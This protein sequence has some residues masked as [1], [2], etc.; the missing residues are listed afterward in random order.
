M[1]ASGVQTAFMAVAFLTVAVVLCSCEQNRPPV[2]PDQQFEVYENGWFVQ[3][4]PIVEASDPDG[5]QL[6]FDITGG[7]EEG[8]FGLHPNT[9]R[10]SLVRPEL[11]DY[12]KVQRHMLKVLVS[13]NHEQY[14]LESSAS[15]P[16]VVLNYN[17]LSDQLTVYLPFNGDADDQSGN[18]HHGEVH[19]ATLYEDLH[20]RPESAFLFDGQD[21]YVAITDHND[22]SFP[23][24][25]F[26]ISLWVKPL[27]YKSRSYILSKGSG[28]DEL[29]YALGT[30]PDSTFFFSV[31]DRG[32][33]GSEYRVSGTTRV[34]YSDWYHVTGVRDDYMLTLSV[35]AEQEQSLYCDITT[36]N[37]GD[38][39]LIGG[40]GNDGQ[41]SAFH[42]VIDDLYIH[43]RILH[44]WELRGL[45]HQGPG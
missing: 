12:E 7:N 20:G 27:G 22:L 35:N 15:I 23:R 30:G 5:D 42:G 43:R 39:L 31:Y 18:Q 17:E 6:R 37:S 9:G 25:D 26:T 45:Y 10:L 19:G 8:I 28:D 4:D 29:E 32:R 40:F 1:E 13:D 24:S 21:D 34:N 33:P 11:L 14:P 3:Y 16:I 41:D 38:D 44:W 36:L 2:I